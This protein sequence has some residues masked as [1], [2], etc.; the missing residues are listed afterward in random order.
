MAEGFQN[1][2]ENFFHIARHAELVFVKDRDVVAFWPDMLPIGSNDGMEIFRD[3]AQSFT[4]YKTSGPQ[5]IEASE[6]TLMWARMSGD[7]I[8]G[9]MRWVPY[10]TDNDADIET[11]LPLRE[12]IAPRVIYDQTSN[13]LSL[14]FWTNVKN[15]YDGVVYEESQLEPVTAA[16]FTGG[17]PPKAKRVLCYAVG[18]FYH[19]WV[20]GGEVSGYQTSAEGIT[21]SRW[22]LVPVF[23]RPRIINWEQTED[24]KAGVVVDGWYVTGPT[25]LTGITGCQGVQVRLVHDMRFEC[26][27]FEAKYKDVVVCADLFTSPWVA[28]FTTTTCETGVTAPPCTPTP[29]PT[30]PTGP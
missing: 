6:R 24:N 26:G 30:G 28:I 17:L 10:I 25:G 4:Q 8:V 9:G 29:T 15:D 19:S 18:E 1:N 7:E 16:H 5:A 11:I 27:K 12:V 14:W 2:Q 3:G 13:T 23:T 20:D 21:D 22:D